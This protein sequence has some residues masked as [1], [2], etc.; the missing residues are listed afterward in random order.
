MITA[1]F[2]PAIW[3]FQAIEAENAIIV[4]GSQGGTGKD[5]DRHRAGLNC[6]FVCRNL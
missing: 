5:P 1:K 3:Y 2:K 4:L 6:M